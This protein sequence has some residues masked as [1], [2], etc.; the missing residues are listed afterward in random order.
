M[1]VEVELTITF[2]LAS[3]DHLGPDRMTAAIA[4]ELGV[5]PNRIEIV[6]VKSTTSDE[7][8]SA[9]GTAKLRPPLRSV[10]LAPGVRVTGP[11]IHTSQAHPDE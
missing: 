7:G 10:T 5:S 6:S 1:T 4:A 9:T 8:S 3:P 11:I 2:K